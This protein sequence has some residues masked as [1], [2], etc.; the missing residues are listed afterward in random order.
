M[1]AK[2]RDAAS[3]KDVT[4]MKVRDGGSWKTV[5]EAWVRDGGSW[6][7]FFVGLF[8]G[9][10]RPDADVETSDWTSTP[11]WN[12]LDEVSPDDATTEVSAIFT[13]NFQQTKNFEVGLSNPAGPPSG[14]ETV[15][16]RVRFWLQ[17][18][19][20]DVTQRSVK[21]E[22][23][24]LSTIK[25]TYNTFASKTGYQ[26]TI[27]SIL[28]QAVKDSINNWNNLRVRVEY[29]VTGDS[30]FAQSWGRVTWIELEFS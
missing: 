8:I 13:G 4:A 23:K 25:K 17:L 12:K 1:T 3:W 30:E 6:K 7:S 28:S 10:L 22:L 29:K 2:V 9:F 21:I 24:E 20:Q 16:L 14:S 11:L 19:F 27:N 5:K 15:T 18:V 26:T